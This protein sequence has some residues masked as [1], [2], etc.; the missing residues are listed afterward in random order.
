MHHSYI[1]MAR[2]N[3]EAAHTFTQCTRYTSVSSRG[4]AL[5]HDW[6]RPQ[7]YCAYQI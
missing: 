3:H 4:Y 6:D 5:G 2:W 7:C 1:I